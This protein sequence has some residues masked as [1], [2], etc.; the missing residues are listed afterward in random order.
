MQNLFSGRA[1]GKLRYILGNR[2]S[3]SGE[4]LNE[5]VVTEGNLGTSF[6]SQ[7]AKTLTR[8]KKLFL[9]LRKMECRN[10]SILIPKERKGIMQI[11]LIVCA[12]YFDLKYR[13]S[14]SKQRNHRGILLFYTDLEHLNN[15]SL[16]SRC[17][18]TCIITANQETCFLQLR[19]CFVALYSNLKFSYNHF[20]RERRCESTLRIKP[21]CA[22]DQCIS[23]PNKFIGPSVST[24]LQNVNKKAVT[25]SV[26]STR[27]IIVA[28]A[29]AE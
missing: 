7:D 3:S 22:L 29:V 9:Q 16:V 25:F 6:Q 28:I 21:F 13:T 4:L 19:S 27:Q 15:A 5:I 18:S 1:E 2:K 10:N 20:V 11:R 8:A 14:C 26:Y 24:L 17:V 12:R 23:F